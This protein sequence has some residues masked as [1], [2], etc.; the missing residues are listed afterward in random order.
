MS[1]QCNSPGELHVAPILPA[2]LPPDPERPAG[3]P[4][5]A[6]RPA[7]APGSPSLSTGNASPPDSLERLTSVE[8][9]ALIAATRI[10]LNTGLCR[11]SARHQA[12]LR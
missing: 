4:L 9:P 5:R 12:L 1:E 6:A 3:T 11:G 10:E 2:P 8:N 7:P